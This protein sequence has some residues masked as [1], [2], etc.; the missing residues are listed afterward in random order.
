MVESGLHFDLVD[1][2][3]AVFAAFVARVVLGCVRL[4]GG[5]RALLLD[6]EGAKSNTDVAHFTPELTPAVS[7]P[8]VL[9]GGCVVAPA[10]HGD[11]VVDALAGTLVDAASVLE[12]W[13]SVNAA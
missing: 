8:P 11:D 12:D 3:L 1:G 4:D 5:P 2:R 7:D 13:P 9:A 10:G 6:E